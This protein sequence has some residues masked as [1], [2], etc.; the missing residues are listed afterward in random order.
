[1]FNRQWLTKNFQYKILRRIESG[2]DMK[3]DTFEEIRLKSNVYTIW[4]DT[5]M[6]NI[7]RNVQN[8]IFADDWL[9]R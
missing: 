4:Y 3:N 8:N 6:Q 5:I 9:R 2:F 1:M 7:H